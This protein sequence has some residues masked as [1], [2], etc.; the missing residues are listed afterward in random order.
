MSSKGEHTSNHAN[1]GIVFGG[2]RAHN[3][4]TKVRSEYR[5]GRLVEM[6]KK[7]GNTDYSFKSAKFI[8]IILLTFSKSVNFTTILY[9]TS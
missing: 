1:A 2:F 5:G 4:T 8:I 9:N 7:Y 3:F 6:L